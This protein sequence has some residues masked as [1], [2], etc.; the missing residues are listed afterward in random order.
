MIEELHAKAPRRQD[1]N[2]TFLLWFFLAAWREPP[3]YVNKKHRKIHFSD[4]SIFLL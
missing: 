3:S 1:T 4:E 2:L